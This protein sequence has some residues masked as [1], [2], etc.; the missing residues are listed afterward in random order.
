VHT[1]PV[2]KFVGQ[3]I[4]VVASAVFVA[5]LTLTLTGSA[6]AAPT[7]TLSEVQH[8]LAKYQL[9]AEKLDQQYVQVLQQLHSTDHRL[10]L[11]DKQLGTFNAEFLKRRAEITR[12]AVTAYEDGNM[13]SSI[14][15]LT[16]GDPQQIL[17]QSSILQELAAGNQEQIAQFVSAAKQLEKT[18]QVA[19]RA[20]TAVLQLKR[21]LDK[22]KAQMNKL[23]RTERALV[24]QLTPAQQT[25]VA[26]TGTS[27]VTYTGPTSSQAD[28]AVAYAYAQVGCPYVFG[29]TGPCSSG[30]DCSGLTMESWAHAGVS[31]PRTSY[32]QWASLPHVSLSAVQPGDILVFYGAGH[33]AIYV[34][35]NKF[36]QA[37]TPGQDVQ[38]VTYQ[39]ASTPGIDGAVR[40]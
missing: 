33:V 27:K 30:F 34:G 13:T 25:S 40:P 1:R 29:G 22:R 37:P 32:D 11:V 28:K 21:N 4:A 5:G 3:R 10:G 36:I 14:A 38:I 7:P 23:V 26:E 15:L 8:K 6:G 24:A 39:G 16:S 12:I 18:Q 17:D 2:R 9:Q 35:N 19:S 31:I 20:H